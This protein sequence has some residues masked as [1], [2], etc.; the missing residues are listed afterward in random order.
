LVGPWCSCVFL[1]RIISLPSP[2]GHHRRELPGGL[3]LDKKE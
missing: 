2:Q 1:A 3:W